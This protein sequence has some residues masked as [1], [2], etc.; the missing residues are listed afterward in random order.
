MTTETA[1]RVISVVEAIPR[2]RVMTYGEVGRAVGTNALSVGRILNKYG[3]MLSWWRVVDASGRPYKGALERAE[4]HFTEESTPLVT[5]ARDLR[6]D[7]KRASWL[8][9]GT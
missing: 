9:N 5:D 6:V 8:P 4:A 7:L 1:N 3:H 2:G